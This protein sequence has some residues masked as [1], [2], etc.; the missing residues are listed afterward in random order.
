[1]PPKFGGGEKCDICKK[2]VYA[3]ERIEA[4]K[5]PFHKLCFKCSICKMTLKLE[6]YAQAD[7]ILYCKKHYQQQIVAKNTQEPAAAL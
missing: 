6:N 3:N 5:R 1:M 7:G 4:G 2:S